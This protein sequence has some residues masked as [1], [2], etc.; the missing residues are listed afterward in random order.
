MLY[1]LLLLAGAQRFATPC[2]SGTMVA[3]GVMLA[4]NHGLQYYDVNNERI[5]PYFHPMGYEVH[6]PHQPQPYSTFPPGY[7]L[8]VAFVYRLTGGLDAVYLIAPS[9]GLLGL[10][11]AAYVGWTLGGSFTSL[12]TVILLGTSFVFFDQ[13]TVWQSDGPSL[14]L[15]LIS[16]ALYQ[17]AYRQR[18]NLLAV[19]RR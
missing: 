1:A 14:S 10:I 15:L 6:A 2:D 5:S 18:R 3:Q 7:P 4:E 12:L 19:T 16:V 9:L 11:A 17:A 13:S 8:L